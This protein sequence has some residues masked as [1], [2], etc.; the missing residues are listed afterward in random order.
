MS[1]YELEPLQRRLND[2]VMNPTIRRVIGAEKSGLNFQ[3]AINN[4]KIIL[5]DIQKGE[6]GDTVSELIGSIIITK[7]WA[8]AQSRVTQPIEQRVPF[9][10]YIDELQNFAGEGSNFT[11]ILSEAREYRLGCWLASQYLHQLTP[12]MRRAVTNNCRTKIVFN[13]AGS[14]DISQIARMLQG[15]DKNNLTRLGKYRAA[16]Q[17]PG[18][19]TQQNA[20]TFDTYPPWEADYTNVENIKKEKAA[21]TSTQKT[22]ITLD[23]SL[24]KSNNAGKEAHQELL[25][26]AKKELEERG[27]TVNLLYQNPGDDKPDGH[28]HLPSGEIAH[29]EAELSTLSK[30]VK[31][32]NNLQR[33]AEKDR[34]TI[35]IVQHGKAAKL[36]NIVDDPKNRRGN[37]Y[38]DENGSYS[39]YTFDGEPFADF[40]TIEEA[41]YRILEHGEDLNEYT[42]QETPDCPELEDHDREGLEAACLYREENGFCTALETPCVLQ[43][44]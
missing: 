29:L 30:P 1:S 37:D 41:E 16:I 3:H 28:V 42:E 40:E 2:F 18:E 23:Q 36:K 8:A 22:E 43:D 10:L 34:E 12:K 9:H 17:K 5:V 32:L 24:G 44:H 27:F 14:D 21:A 33:A 38:E 6:I 11:K 15:L 35:F 26:E 19:R 25:A 13:P 39:Y 7:I 31:I 20:V 4:G